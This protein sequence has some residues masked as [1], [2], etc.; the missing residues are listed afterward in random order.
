MRRVLATVVVVL[1]LMGCEGDNT[2][3]RANL[4]V[5]FPQAPFNAVTGASPKHQ[6]T[7]V[8]STPSQQRIT[9]QRYAMTVSMF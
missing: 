6:A 8:L 5:D 2:R 3:E 9:S 1:G 4:Q 7:Q